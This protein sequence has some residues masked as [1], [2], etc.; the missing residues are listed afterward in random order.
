MVA[1][2]VALLLVGA[3]RLGAPH[4]AVYLGVPAVLAM[5]LIASQIVP[6][7]F[8]RHA[9]LLLSFLLDHGEEYGDDAVQFGGCLVHG[10]YLLGWIGLVV[11]TLLLPAGLSM[12]AAAALSGTAVMAAP[13]LDG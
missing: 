12:A 5:A 1:V 6:D 3:A 11:S 4:A 13:F 10:A 9:M 2:A 7:L 8:L